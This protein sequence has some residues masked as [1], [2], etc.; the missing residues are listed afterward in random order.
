M[1]PITNMMSRRH[2]L[3]K[4]A[5]TPLVMAVAAGAICTG[6]GN[7]LAA[8]ADASASIDTQQ[9]RSSQDW[10]LLNHT[11][12]P[13]YGNWNAK[14]DSA[15][16]SSH[17]ETD[18]DHPWAPDDAAKATQNEN[19]GG[20]LWAGRICFDRNWWEYTG[21]RSPENAVF[22]LEADSAGELYVYHDKDHLQPVHLTVRK[23]AC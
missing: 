15:S 17:V 22:T 11:G 2:R 21:Y 1:T 3:R 13:I 19:W 8:T 18:K 6:A 7:G 20:T 4:L 16:Y 5:Y 12:Q 9:G 10:Y 23:G 14:M